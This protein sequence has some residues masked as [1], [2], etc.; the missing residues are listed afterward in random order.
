ML[1]ANTFEEAPWDPNN[2][3]QVN[4]FFY[5]FPYD[6]PNATN[7]WQA[8]HYNRVAPA[9]SLAGLGRALGAISWSSLPGWGQIAIVAL[10]SA[11]V[12]YFGMSKWGDSHIKP[13]LRKVGIGR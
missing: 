9:G 3:G 11:A 6:N 5:G 8:V 10:S 12:G 4:H 7:G 13:A 1:V 2:P